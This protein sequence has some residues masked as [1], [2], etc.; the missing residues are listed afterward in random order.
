MDFTMCVFVWVCT[1]QLKNLLQVGEDVLNV[2]RRQ[3][4]LLGELLVEN[5]I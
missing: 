2:S 4:C 1:V 5:V 3:D